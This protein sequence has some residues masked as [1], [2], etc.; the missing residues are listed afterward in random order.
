MI[1][2]E[3]YFY[4]GKIM[5]VRNFNDFRE[6]NGVQK[7][8]YSNGNVMIECEATHGYLDGILRKYA[9]DG[10][11]LFKI[12]FERGYLKSDINLY[13]ITDEDVL[14]YLAIGGVFIHNYKVTS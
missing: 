3:S 4:N 11:V 2:Y 5:E 12:E 10:E 8:F 7:K 9:E 13:K 14:V 6:L 1:S